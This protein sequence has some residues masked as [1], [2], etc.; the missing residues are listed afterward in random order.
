[1]VLPPLSIR[2]SS[3]VAASQ[4]CS[5]WANHHKEG[6]FARRA[7]R[8]ERAVKSSPC[9]GRVPRR[10]KWGAVGATRDESQSCGEG[11]DHRDHDT[12]PPGTTPKLASRARTSPDRGRSDTRVA[13]VSRGT[14]GM[15]GVAGRGGFGRDRRARV[16]RDVA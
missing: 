7:A 13:V 4:I 15:G 8:E 2:A 11:S 9:G 1:V 3:A 10:V 5:T 6:D 16:R 14:A 12:E